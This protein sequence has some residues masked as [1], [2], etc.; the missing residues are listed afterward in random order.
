MNC[1]RLKNCLIFVCACVF[2]KRVE[3]TAEPNA[4][5]EMFPVKNETLNNLKRLTS[6]HTHTK[7]KRETDPFELGNKI[8][9]GIKDVINFL[10]N[11][12]SKHLITLLKTRKAERVFNII[13]FN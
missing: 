8:R 4:Q 12:I 2:L 1:F 7:W 9:T 3:K 13:N 11:S 10:V 5:K 6:I